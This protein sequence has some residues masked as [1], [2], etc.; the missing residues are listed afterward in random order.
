VKTLYW[1]GSSLDALRRFPEAVK[2]IVGYA[3]YLAQ[4]SDKH[5]DAK[6]LRGFLGSG[7]L[8]VVADH[9]GDTYRAVY[10]IRFRD[11]VYVLHAFQKKSKKGI[12]TPK[13]D[14]ELIRTRLKQAHEHYK[15]RGGTDKG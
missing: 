10:T 11:A 3:L 5:P 15:A 8:E 6:P 9:Q 14:M 1:M 2:D 12:A 7:T 4:E 13:H